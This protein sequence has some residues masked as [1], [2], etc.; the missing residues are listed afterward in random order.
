[1]NG[2]LKSAL[3]TT[4]FLASMP[5]DKYGI[6][7]TQVRTNSKPERKCGRSEC[8]NMTTHNGGYCS[9]I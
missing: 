5:T 3:L 9:A 7:V 6:P 1:M 8:E 4:L 2:S